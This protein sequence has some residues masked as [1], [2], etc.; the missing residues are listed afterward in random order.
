MREKRCSDSCNMDFQAGRQTRNE[1]F[2][3]LGVKSNAKRVRVRQFQNTG[4]RETRFVGV[5]RGLLLE[6]DFYQKPPRCHF[7]TEMVQKVM[8]H[9]TYFGVGKWGHQ[10]RHS[11]VPRISHSCR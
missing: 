7:V 9:G 1:K 5:E 4:E 6:A 10:R 8:H 11:W 2:G 3:E